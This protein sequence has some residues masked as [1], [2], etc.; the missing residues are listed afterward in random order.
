MGIV[1]KVSW[2]KQPQLV[3]GRAGLGVHLISPACLPNNSE[4]SILFL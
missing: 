4:N 2:S 1:M 3:S